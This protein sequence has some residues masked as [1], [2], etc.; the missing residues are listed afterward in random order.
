MADA[1]DDQADKETVVAPPPQRGRADGEPTIADTLAAFHQVE[2]GSLPPAGQDDTATR[3]EARELLGEGGM[4]SIRLY[5]DRRVGRDVAMKVIHPGHGSRSDLRSRFVR[6]ARVQG[7][8]EH[9]SIVPVYDLSLYP[10][11]AFFTMKRVRGVTLEEV[12]GL[13]GKANP[14]ARAR[15]SRRKLLTAFGSVCLA[16]DFAH[17]HGVVHRDLKPA[18]V[19]LGDFGEVY[20]LDWGIARVG[21]TDVPAESSQKAVE[22]TIDETGERIAKT[23]AGALLG[24]LGYMAPEQLKG[25]PVDGRADVYALGAILFEL[26]ALVPLHTG[27]RAAEI[28]ASTLTGA[29][30]RPSVRAPERDV[31]PELETIC[32]RATAVAPRDRFA[33]A[34]EL[35]DAVEQFLDGDR[36]LELRAKMAE[37]HARTAADAAARARIGVGAPAER[38]RSLALREVGRALAL[39]PTN[40]EALR[41]TMALVTEPPRVLP[42][43]ARAT[44]D[45]ANAGMLRSTAVAGAVWYATTFLYFPLFFWMGVR[46]WTIPVASYSLLAVAALSSALVSARP[47][48]TWA[49]ITPFVSSTIAFSLLS[50]LMGAYII[51]PAILVAN[52]VAYVVVPGRRHRTVAL[53]VGSLGLIVPVILEAVGVWSPSYS[54]AGGTFVVLPHAGPFAARPTQIFL[55]VLTLSTII[56]SITFV[57]RVRRT[58]D[59]AEERLHLQ[60]WQLRQLAPDAAKG[61]GD[62]SLPS[63][64]CMLEEG[65]S[66]ACA[67]SGAATPSSPS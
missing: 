59:R 41:T 61:A 45:S 62:V 37:G 39:D 26:L 5:K 15:F 44:L 30:A 48:A 38:D 50:R 66:A 6:E 29:D 17:V 11:P 65:P 28:V 14:D 23:E 36:D 63:S 25:E 1:R 32:I 57:D 35:H 40:A 19:M 2:A 8:L 4:G 67:P 33:S 60:A 47:R 55:F 52:T 10:E 7:Q 51:L 31:P 43:E 58:L 42:A 34:R 53:V 27:A 3:Y 54:F 12:I 64:G 22:F 20:V 46:D 24:T 13:L 18:N 21:P 16:V 9:P 49:L 56:T